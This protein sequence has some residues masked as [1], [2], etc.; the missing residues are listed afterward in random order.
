MEEERRHASPEGLRSEKDAVYIVK[1]NENEK[2]TTKTMN[3]Y[4]KNDFFRFSMFMFIVFS[5]STCSRPDTLPCV[6][7]R[8]SYRV[9]CC[10]FILFISISAKTPSF[11][12]ISGRP[13]SKKTLKTRCFR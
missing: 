5:Q 9:M 3:K 6:F 1:H 2:S 7:G 12:S 8:R 10:F 4:R 11:E 13:S